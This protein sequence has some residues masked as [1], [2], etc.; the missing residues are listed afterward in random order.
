MS[1]KKQT[2]I[3]IKMKALLRFKNPKNH[4]FY[5]RKLTAEHKR[6]ISLSHGGTGIPSYNRSKYSYAFYRIKKQI[7]MRD[8]RRCQSCDITG[9]DVHH[10]DYNKNNNIVNNL[11][12]LCHKCNIKANSNRDY[13]YAYF[14]YIMQDL[15]YA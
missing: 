4:P 14:I 15:N 9:Y 11:I 3:L 10:I 2:K 12:T 13:W 8:H 6:N 1:G 5:G 7:R